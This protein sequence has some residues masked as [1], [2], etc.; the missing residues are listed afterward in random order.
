MTIQ[1]VESRPPRVSLAVQETVPGSGR[2]VNLTV[3]NGGEANIRDVTARLTS[4]DLQFVG[5]PG[6]ASRLPSGTNRTFQYTTTVTEDGT[7]PVTVLLQY[8]KNGQT[9]EL[10]RT[11]TGDFTGPSNP[12]QIELT[13]VEVSRT[14]AGVELAATASNLGSTPVDGVVVSIRDA[15]GVTPRTYFVGNVKASDFSSFTL[16]TQTTG[17]VSA[18][19]V[20]VRYVVDGVEQT[21]TRE[22]PLPERQTP[23]PVRSD[24]GG[25]VLPM[26]AGGIAF[27]VVG[28]MAVVYFR[29]R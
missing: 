15:P 16:A 25:S 8:V 17:N 22:L 7:Y 13:G 21:T 29:Q 18:L 1:A 5:N 20:E 14:G 6:V 4:P 26:V 2:D 12:G 3:S 24:D 19:P 27:T 28:I 10:T 9:R 23:R 11:V